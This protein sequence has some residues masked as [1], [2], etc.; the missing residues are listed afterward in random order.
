MLSISSAYGDAQ[1]QFVDRKLIVPMPPYWSLGIIMYAIMRFEYGLIPINLPVNTPLPMTAD[2]MD[3][4]HLLVKYCEGGVYGTSPMLHSVKTE[5]SH[6]CYYAPWI[7]HAVKETRL[8]GHT[9]AFTSYCLSIH[10]L[11]PESSVPRSSNPSPKTQHI[12]TT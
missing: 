4:V 10:L 6:E 1:E 9:F 8:Q 5:M 7:S 3:G 2:Y 12:C 11:T